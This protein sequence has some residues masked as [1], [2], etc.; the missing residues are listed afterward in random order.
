MRTFLRLLAVTTII[1]V[2]APIGATRAADRGTPEEAKVM[3]KKATALVQS[4]GFDKATAAF[5]AVG[6]PFRDRDLYVFIWN[7]E[8]K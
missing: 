6:G 1:L 3:A 5:A 2:M 7:T 4:E 8:G